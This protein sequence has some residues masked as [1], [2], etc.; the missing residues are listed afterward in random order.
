[1]FTP[2]GMQAHRIHAGILRPAGYDGSKRVISEWVA[3]AGLK[4]SWHLKAHGNPGF[5]CPF[6]ALIEV[7]RPGITA[8]PMLNINHR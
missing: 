4:K 5:Q 2:E 7:D 1:M 3:I 8:L 6:G